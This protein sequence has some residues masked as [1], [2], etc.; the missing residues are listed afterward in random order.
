[1]EEEKEKIVN[2]LK[3]ENLNLKLQL[4]NILAYEKCDAKF[5]DKNVMKTHIKSGY[6]HEMKTPKQMHDQNL[7]F[8]LG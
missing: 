8:K 3:E 6:K 7:T 2:D 1:M 4:D 5:Q